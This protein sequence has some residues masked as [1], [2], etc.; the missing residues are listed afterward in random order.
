MKIAPV[1]IDCS[2]LTTLNIEENIIAEKFSINQIYP[3]PFNPNLTI[4]YEISSFGFIS[5]KIMNLKGQV[6]D[7]LI[8]ENKIP[9]MYSIHWDGSL[10]P[11]GIYLIQ[12]NNES[13]ISSQ[14]MILLK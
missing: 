14:K 10:H 11:S 13:D 9:G 4:D 1:K 12:M 6:I 7:I 5:I 8:S 2:S 3:N